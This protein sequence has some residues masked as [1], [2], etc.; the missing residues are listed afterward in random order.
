M[1]LIDVP[2]QHSSRRPSI[3]MVT[4][5]RKESSSDSD[6]DNEAESPKCLKCK[7]AC[8]QSK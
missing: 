7:G 1:R 8:I 6:T 5:A 2:L 3:A 4:E